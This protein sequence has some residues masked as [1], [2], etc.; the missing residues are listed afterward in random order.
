MGEVKLRYYTTRPRKSGKVG[1]WQPTKAMQECGFQL[2]PCG[3]DG[4]DA[5]AIAEKWNTRWDAYRKTGETAKWPVGSFGAAFDDLRKTGIWSDKKPRTRDDWFRG[6][7]YIEPVF[8]D[9]APPVVTVQ[10]I[11]TWYRDVLGTAGVREAWRAMKIWR[12][13]WVQ[14]AALRYCDATKDPSQAIRR[15]T[16][17]AR[18]DVWREGEVTRLVKIAWRSGYR[19]L[20]AIIATAW[21]TGFSPVDVR[22]LTFAQIKGEG[23]RLAFEIGRA[24]TGRAALG[25]LGKRSSAIVRAYIATLPGEHLPSACVFRHRHGLPYSKDT[26]GDDFRDIR[27]GGERRTLADMR[28]S[29]AVEAQAGGASDDIIAQK[30]ANDV[31]SNEALR[32]TYLPVNEAAVRAVDEARKIGRQNIRRTKSLT[33]GQSESNESATPKAKVSG[34]VGKTGERDGT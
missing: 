8:G 16:P 15:K 27:G 20:A 13:L 30:L 12:A 11:D 28:R 24:K 4:P 26:L 21:D 1:Y 3:P 31:S 2:V 25:T 23:D 6:W 17:E 33:S 18:H 34:I 32:R 29:G 5:W 7:R 9:M 19:G 10:M 22:K 14:A